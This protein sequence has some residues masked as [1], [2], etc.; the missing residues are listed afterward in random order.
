[1]ENK[2][3]FEPAVIEFE[4][5]YLD[6]NNLRFTNFDGNR[7][8][9]LTRIKEESV[10]KVTL[11]K[12]KAEEFQVKALRDSIVELGF[13]PIDRIVVSKI[14]EKS[15]L[16][17]EGNR[18]LAALKW[19]IELIKEGIV[20]EDVKKS[21]ERIPVNILNPESDTEGNR[22]KIQGIRHIS[23]IRPWGTYQK[24]VLIKSMIEGE[25]LSPQDVANAIGYRTT[26]VNRIYQAYKLLEQ[27]MDD[28]D[29]GEFAKP[30][31]ISFFYEAVGRNPLKA[32]FG[33]DK[34]TF[35]F[36]NED[37]Y[38]LFYKWII[39]DQDNANM[40]KIPS[41]LNVRDL[42][43]IIG[44]EEALASFKEDSTTMPEALAIVIKYSSVDWRKEITQAIEAIKKLPADELESLNG[45][46]IVLLTSLKEMIEK[47]ID[48]YG[49]IRGLN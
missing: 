17:V 25:K 39:K 24:A 28:P 44:N 32:F 8:V 26:E 27:M 16:V 43:K 13:L 20:E 21:F 12:L 35:K 15:Y 4:Q 19:I 36:E 37:N 31:L 5:L 29:Y 33:Y 41:P 30:D 9:P 1:M 47:R 22:L 42:T 6:P 48:L 49:K 3:E 45:E 11:E 38:K 34:D 14:D 23:E 10:Q 7:R 46:D 2:I 18:R 40:Q